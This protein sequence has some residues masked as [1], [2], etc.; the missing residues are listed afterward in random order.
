MSGAGN[1]VDFPRRKPRWRRVLLILKGT[2]LAVAVLSAAGA[3]YEML[4]ASGDA[5]RYPVP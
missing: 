4:A 1:A 3:G 2:T 5:E